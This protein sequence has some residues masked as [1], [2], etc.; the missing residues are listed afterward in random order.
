[1]ATKT[2]IQGASDHGTHEAIYLPDPDGNDIELAADRPRG[3]P[4]R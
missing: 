4:N 1:M 3:G 2:P